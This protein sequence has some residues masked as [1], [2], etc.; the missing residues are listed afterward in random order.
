MSRK[1]ARL[2]TLT[3][4]RMNSLAKAPQKKD[5]VVSLTRL[6]KGQ[7]MRVH[8]LPVGT[9]RAQLIRLGFNEGAI[10]VCFERLPG[11]TIVL[12]KNRQLIAIGHSL[13]KEILVV[14][15]NGGE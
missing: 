12:Q 3:D 14:F 15:Q 5:K 13:A 6:K 4:D 10:V 2:P 8:S 7:V 1:N 9:L 11:G